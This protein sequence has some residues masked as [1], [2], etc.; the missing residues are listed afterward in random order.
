LMAATLTAARS[1]FRAIFLTTVT[2]FAGLLPLISS[3]GYEAEK[4]TPMA[5]TIAFGVLF[6]FFVTLFLVPAVYAVFSKTGLNNISR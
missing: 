1:R 4:I 5:V 2:T 3:Q 6:T